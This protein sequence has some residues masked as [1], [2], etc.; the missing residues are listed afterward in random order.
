M[1]RCMFNRA[2]LGDVSNLAA[3]GRTV[4]PVGGKDAVKVKSRFYFGQW[5]I[6]HALNRLSKGI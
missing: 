5:E 1:A 3:A 4:Q 6:A 2:P